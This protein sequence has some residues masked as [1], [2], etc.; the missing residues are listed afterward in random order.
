MAFYE[1]QL[2]FW[3]NFT[4]VCFYGTNWQK[5]SYFSRNSHTSPEPMQKPLS[6]H[7]S[8][9]L[10]DDV[11]KWKQFLRYWPFVQGIHRW[12]V[13]SPHKGQWRGSLMF[14]L[15]CVWISGWVNNREAG[16]LRPYRTHC[17]VTAWCRKATSH[18]MSQCWPRSMSLYMES[19]GHS[20]DNQFGSILLLHYQPSVIMSL[21]TKWPTLRRRHFQMPLFKCNSMN[22]SEKP[23]LNL[24]PLVQ[25][26]AWRR[27]G[28]KQLSELMT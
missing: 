6:W 14:S 5:P 3:F 12:P 28:D 16:D 4:D 11:I 25:P 27:L 13:N 8:S 9:F 10:H 15:I 21:W 20:R 18:F 2:L 17:D 23:H 24:P 22:F 19:P 7:P 26:V 1:I